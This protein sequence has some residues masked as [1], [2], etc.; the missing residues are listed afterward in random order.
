M[1]NDAPDPFKGV[2]TGE[3]LA[4]M[5][6]SLCDDFHR[7]GEEWENRT[8]EDCL[9]LLAARGDASSLPLDVLCAGPQRSRPVRVAERRCPRRA[10]STGN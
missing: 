5:I 2:M 3:S 6:H 9:G 4:A 1:S 10:R 8:V 7:G